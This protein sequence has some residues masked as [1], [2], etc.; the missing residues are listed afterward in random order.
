MMSI[1]DA[2]KDCV[3]ENKYMIKSKIVTFALKG[4]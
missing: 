1:H 2:V 3:I 4:M